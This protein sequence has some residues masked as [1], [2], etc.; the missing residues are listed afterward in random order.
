MS[1]TQDKIFHDYKC[2]F[3]DTNFRIDLPNYE[4]RN[5]IAKK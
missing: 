1:T 2:I 3:G 5:L 4:V